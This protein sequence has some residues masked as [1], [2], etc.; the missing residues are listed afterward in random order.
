MAREAFPT[1]PPTIP[2]NVIDP[3]YRCPEH[4]YVTASDCPEC[5]RSTKEV[6][7]GERRRR[8]S[9]FIN[10]ALRH[11]PE[12]AGLEL[13]DRGWT[14]WDDL[15]DAVGRKY[16]WTDTRDLAAVVQTDPKGRFERR[17]ADGRTSIRAA[18]GHSVDVDLD[19]GDA[20]LGEDHAS[21]D[22]GDQL[23]AGGA[24]GDETIPNR[25]YHG[26][27]P[28]NL[29]SILARGLRPMERQEVHLSGTP[30]DAREVGRRHANRPALLEIDAEGMVADGLRISKRGKATYTADEV[31]PEYVE[32][33]ER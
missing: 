33:R 20:G 8:L 22:E 28:A 10:G 17:E 11:F 4:G 1:R 16:D 24:G 14:E 9:K 25:L 15:A 19:G 5:G 13:D 23:D 30:A 6:L 27:D 26:T 21:E 7:S 32:V 29:D 2:E 3:I 12:D 31:P 18:Y